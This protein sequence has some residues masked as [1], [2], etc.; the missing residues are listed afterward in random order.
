MEEKNMKQFSQLNPF[1]LLGY[2]IAAIGFSMFIMNPVCLGISFVGAF[3]SSVSINGAKKA[4]H[5]LKYMLP[6]LFIAVLVNPA[7]NHEGATILEYL[8][9][10]N[11]L[12][13][14]SIAYGAAAGAM[15]AAVVCHFSGFN[16]VMT[17]DKLVYIF[18]RFLP[19]LSLIF[20]MTLRFVPR[21]NS[22]MK[23]VRAAQK[24][25]GRDI[26][27]GGTIQR[28]KNGITIISIM[29]TRSLEGAVETADSM[30]SRGYGLKGRTSFAMFRFD[31]RDAII[32]AIILVAACAIVFAYASGILYW[33]YF[34]TMRG[35]ENNAAA[36]IVYA[37]YAAIMT[38]PAVINAK[39]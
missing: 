37:V 22:Q 36:F 17:S 33:R 10:G 12:T 16:S 7:F 11:P 2:Y 13:L 31:K 21:F 20:S 19:S 24:C 15:L 30:K 6:M 1:V 38:M 25:I 35:H 28:I 26:S 34:P 29:I 9:N 27:S 8:P 4:A 3:I 23:K 18:G 14:E 32:L 39:R 5:S